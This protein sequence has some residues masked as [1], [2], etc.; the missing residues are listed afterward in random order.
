M[1]TNNNF[2]PPKSHVADVAPENN[3][4]LADRGTRL[5]AAIVDGLMFVIPLLPVYIPMFRQ[6][7]RMR[8][9]A[10]AQDGAALAAQYQGSFGWIGI[11]SLVVLVLLIVDIVFVYK[12]SQTIGKRMFNIKVVR[13]DGSRASFSRIFWL[14]GFVNGLISVALSLIPIIGR[15]YSLV[16]A[17]FIFGNARRCV[18]DYIADTI[19]VKA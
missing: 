15:L 9:P 10:S 11:G 19:V 17:C 5:L 4:E 7:T 14:R 6:M 3:A 8:S 13:T 16:D 18:H 1:A 12:Y 2:A